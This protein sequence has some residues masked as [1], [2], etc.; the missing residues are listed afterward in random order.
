MQ[1]SK[2]GFNKI[3]SQE[4]GLHHKLTEGQITMI[5]VGGAIGTG[6]FMGSGVAIGMAGPSVLISFIISACIALT[7]MGCLAEMTVAH[8]TT[9]SFGAYAEHYVG[10]LAGFLVRY[11]YWMGIVMAIGTEIT[12]IAIYMHYWFPDSP[13]WIWISI[14]SAALILINTMSVN[15]FGTT[16]YWFSMIKI[17]AIV[18]FIFIGSYIIFTSPADGTI[19]FKNYVDHDGFFPHGFKGTWFATIVA[20]FSFFGIEMVAIAAGEAKQP[21]KSVA[22]AFKTTMGRLFIFYICTLAVMLA[23]VPWTETAGTG[24]SPFVQAMEAVQIP[25]AAG[26]INFVVLVAAL[27]AINSQLYIASRMMFSLARAGHAPAI[28]GKLSSQGSPVYAMAVSFSGVILALILSVFY[29]ESFVVVMAIS[30]FGPLFSWGMI[31]VT[32]YFFRIRWIKEGHPPLQFRIPGFPFL[33][34]FGAFAIAAILISTLL[35][36]QFKAALITGIP[37]LCFLIFMYWLK[38]RRHNKQLVPLRTE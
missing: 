15:I 37:V 17:V 25:G 26:I 8:P 6:L 38:Q 22:R 20:I 35:T 9:G 24:K 16:E 7:L 3:I 12:A 32:H 23:L 36:D 27:S 5:A 2:T 34:V 14:F 28:L 33:T 18:I 13:S 1:K 11:A 31:F 21:E 10:P 4:E 19:G 30:I 29:K